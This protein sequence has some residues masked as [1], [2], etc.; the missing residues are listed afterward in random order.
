MLRKRITILIV[1]DGVFGVFTSQPSNTDMW[2]ASV[3]ADW[4]ITTGQH[5]TS[6]R[7]CD[8]ILMGYYNFRLHNRKRQI[9]RIGTE[10]NSMSNILIRC[11]SDIAIYR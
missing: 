3:T 1:N 8:E 11:K 10:N 5:R 4:K 2:R 9:G 6:N 7:A